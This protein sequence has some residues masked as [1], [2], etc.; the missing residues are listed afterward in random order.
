MLESLL[1]A[2]QLAVEAVAEL[3]W[4]PA[5]ALFVL[6]SAWWVKGPLFLLIGG[7]SDVRA[8]RRLPG[9]ALCAAASLA[10]ATLV[11][12]LLKDLFDRTRPPLA[13]PSV[14]PLVTTPDSPSFPSGHALTAFAAAVAVGALHPRLRWPLVALA[15]LVGLSRVYL[16]VH[17]AL[18]VLAGALIGTIIGLASAYVARAV[19]RRRAPATP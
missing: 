2:D 11:S 19:R 8:R 18:D 12:T 16:G 15:A 3:R 9:T 14:V 5:T 6:I 1:H 17:Y 10:L 13:D 7:L 4:G